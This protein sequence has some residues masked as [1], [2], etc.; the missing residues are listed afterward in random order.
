MSSRRSHVSLVLSL[1]I[2]V[3]TGAAAHAQTPPSAKDFSTREEQRIDR[4]EQRQG[5]RISQG[6]TSG[7]LTAREQR[8]LQRQQLRSQRMEQH[9]EAD[10]KVTGKEALRMERQQDRASRAIRRQKHDVQLQDAGTK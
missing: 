2:A 1:M 9:V 8:R 10:G 6:A 3:L 5:D 4:R 7:Q